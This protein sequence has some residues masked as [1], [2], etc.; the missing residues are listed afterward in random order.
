MDK[1]IL[2]EN[3]THD[4]SGRGI[5]NVSIY[6]KKGETLG[7][8]GPNGAGKSTTIRHLMGYVKPEEGFSSINGEDSFT[9]YYKNNK[10]IGYLPGEVN[11][12]KGIKA[13]DMV[14]YI[15]KLHECKS[16]DFLEH[17]L[18]LFPLDLNMSTK[19]MSV[20]E[21]RKLAII[22]AFLSD[23]DVLVLDEPS[24]GLD[25]LMQERFIEFL[26]T[27]KKRGKTIILSS[28]MFHEVEA[29]CDRIVIIKEG[30]IIREL[31][32]EEVHIQRNK[33]FEITFES[34]SEVAR[35][36][37]DNTDF[38]YEQGEQNVSLIV[39]CDDLNINH[40]IK[41]LT[42]FNV[43]NIYEHVFNFE[44]YFLNFYRSERNFGG[45]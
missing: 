32:Q 17:L 41:A 15:Y 5:Y 31:T 9:N 4:Y 39:S 38:E 13:K 43:L 29:L 37:T 23:P 19:S 45:L 18:N 34:E 28:H 8:L 24:S 1:V 30:K 11:F 44:D 2:T 25:P 6:V 27:E 36:K 12:I 7:F 35:F 16:K 20:G 40:L 33:K 22:L 3:L 26:L 42:R 10:N 14:N 21:K